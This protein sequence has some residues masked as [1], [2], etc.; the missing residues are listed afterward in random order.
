MRKKLCLGCAQAMQKRADIR[1]T[2]KRTQVGICGSCHSKMLVTEYIVPDSVPQSAPKTL[3]ETEPE[4][5]KTLP[6]TEPEQPKAS[7]E[8]W[9]ISLTVDSRTAAAIARYAERWQ[10]TNGEVVDSLMCF[11]KRE[12][13]KRYNHE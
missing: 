4:Q 5:P 7:G 13:R 6:E 10:L 12:M 3:P 8:K 11:Y 2:G 9:T 1:Y